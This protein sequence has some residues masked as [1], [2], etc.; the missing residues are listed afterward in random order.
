MLPGMPSFAHTAKSLLVTQGKHCQLPFLSPIPVSCYT[1]QAFAIIK[2]HH[3]AHMFGIILFETLL[4][5]FVG[6]TT[7]LTPLLSSSVS[8][9][10]QMSSVT[11]QQ[12][13]H[14]ESMAQLVCYPLALLMT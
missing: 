14:Q 3:G 6:L 11:S 12:C 2:K 7:S 13:T 10:H 5:I 8:W 1:A 9:G 4:I